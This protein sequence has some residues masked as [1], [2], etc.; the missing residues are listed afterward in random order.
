MQVY[1]VIAVGKYRWVVMAFFFS[2]NIGLLF[3]AS[4]RF[5]DDPFEC[6]GCFVLVILVF[7]CC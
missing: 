3:F 5:L 7:L 1:I 6:V 2:T 4:D